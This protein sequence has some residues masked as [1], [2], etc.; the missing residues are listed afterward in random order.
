MD[1]TVSTQPQSQRLEL[2]WGGGGEGGEGEQKLE[3]VRNGLRTDQA[4]ET[5]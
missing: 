1:Q 3:E 5:L 2:G 4:R